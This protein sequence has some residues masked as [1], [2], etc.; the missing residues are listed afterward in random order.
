MLITKVIS[1]SILYHSACTK[2]SQSELSKKFEK[3]RRLNI[4]NNN[5]SNPVEIQKSG[6]IITTAMEKFGDLRKNRTNTKLVINSTIG[7]KSQLLEN[8]LNRLVYTSMDD[9]LGKLTISLKE[10]IL[11]VKN[12]YQDEKFRNFSEN[13]QFLTKISEAIRKN[14][15]QDSEKFANLVERKLLQGIFKHTILPVVDKK[16]KPKIELQILPSPSESLEGT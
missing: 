1:I 5:T 3:S 2:T 9:L 12:D 16:E 8:V 4:S 6:L 15:L 7:N 13:S 14:S 10:L 11:S